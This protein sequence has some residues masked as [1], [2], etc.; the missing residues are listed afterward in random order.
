[1]LSR[2]RPPVARVALVVAVFGFALGRASAQTGGPALV[3]YS[4]G[5]EAYLDGKWARAED[6]FGRSAS[7]APA[8]PRPYYFRGLSRLPQGRDAAA[9]A[10]LERGAALEAGKG[11]VFRLGATF[12]SLTGE[13]RRRLDG[14]RT[15]VL[16]GLPAYQD[17]EGLPGGSKRA[18]RAL[19]S[20]FRLTIAQLTTTESPAEL[21][22]LV[23]AGRPQLIGRT[24]GLQAGASRATAAAEGA[25]AERAAGAEPSEQ[26][27]PTIA[28]AA[29]GS[30]TVGQ[31]GGVFGRALG[32]F[33]APVRSLGGA[34]GGPPGRAADPF[35]PPG[36]GSDPFA[37]G[38]GSPR[39]G[40]AEDPFGGGPAGGG[41]GDPFA[42]DS[43]AAGSDPFASGQPAT[44]DSR[45]GEGASAPGS[46]DPFADDGGG[47]DPFG[48][49]FDP[50]EDPFR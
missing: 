12:D 47:D 25:P 44:A 40:D 36:G 34:M 17:G 48:G 11:R 13:P 9:E 15:R 32:S 19:R 31:V 18:Q 24:A 22:R 20:K 27:A 2:P 43:P 3:Y 45:V 29:R 10:D 7:Y 50:G 1:M 39:S 37:G 8:D 14:V 35:G 33:L 28:E 16:S 49:A 30:M 46:Q 5:V 6:Y 41:P 38:G 23:E 21:A 26:T 42:D 4:R